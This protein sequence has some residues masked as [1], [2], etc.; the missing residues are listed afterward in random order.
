MRKITLLLA[1]VF[2]VTFSSPSF[3]EWK[4]VS[5]GT[6]ASNDGDTFYVDFERIRKHGG[7]V[8]WWDLSDYLK[9]TETGTLS[10]KIYKQGDCKLFRFKNLNFSSYKEPMG[11]GTGN[12]DNTPDKEWT[13]PS[14]NSVNEII[15]ES[16]C[17]YAK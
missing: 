7:Y 17:A 14:P 3:A 2:T 1:L 16:V 9:P 13:Y 12:P 15:L 4:K 11:G 8:Y 10:G 6:G 5:D